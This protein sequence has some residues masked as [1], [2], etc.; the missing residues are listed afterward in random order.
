MIKWIR[1][2]GLIAFIV[3]VALVAVIWFIAVDWVAKK[4]IETAGTKAVGA[5]VE[6]AKADV[7]LFP[8]GIGIWGMA[9]A[10]P[11][12]PMTNSLE[13]DYL[14]AALHLPAL[15]QRKVIIDDLRVEGLRLNTPRKRSGAVRRPKTKAESKDD[16]SKPLPGWLAGL[17]GTGN[18]PLISLPN[19]DDILAREPLQSVKQIQ[20]L[21]RR[22]ESA[23]AQWQKK[24]DTLPDQKTLS[25]YQARAKAIKGSG[26]DLVNLLGSASEAQALV[27]DLKKD[28]DQI[29]K[30]RKTFKDD[31]K[32]LEKAAKELSK[33]PAAEIRRLMDK[34][35]FTAGG[36]ANWSRLLFGHNLCGWWQKAYHWYQRLAPYLSRLPAAGDEPQTHRPLRGKGM[37]V[38]FQES[39]PVPDLLI[40][41]V[42]LDAKLETGEFTGQIN[43]ITSHPRILGKP[44][45][46]KFLGRRLQRVQDINLHGMLDFVQPRSPQHTAKLNIRGYQIQDLVLGA[47]TLNLDI[48]RAVADLRLDFNLKDAFTDTR[49]TANLDRLSFA[50]PDKP[51]SELAAVLIDAIRDARNIGL[52][53]TL[54]GREPDYKTSLT[55]DIDRVLQKAAGRLVKRQADQLQARLRTAVNAKLG[56]PIKN[57]Q[58]SMAGLDAIGSELLKRSRLGDEVLKQLKLPL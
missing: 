12:R 29:D 16:P 35:G 34:Y 47:E 36:A 25:G 55:S 57:A 20:A 30:A 13:F 33:L 10:D 46:F 52:E 8:A 19:A 32:S 28:L 14:H 4:A 11:D 3:L 26:K 2:R 9:V 24:L 31:Y 18:L 39:H 37:D 56:E 49:L 22:I 40:R 51:A 5:K 45:T 53:A 7:T 6:V 23:A 15:I 21:E 58:A 1:W 43:N 50:E 42:H 17:C 44:V 27:K 41:Q 38:R 54:K 48:K